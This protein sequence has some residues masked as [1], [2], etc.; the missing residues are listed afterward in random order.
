MVPPPQLPYVVQPGPRAVFADSQGWMAIVDS[1]DASH[2]AASAA[3]E[4]LI[5]TRW[6]IYTSNWTLYEA[7]SHIKE[8]AK[9]GGLSAA[10][11]LRDFAD[12]QSALTI[13]PV[14]KDVESRAVKLFWDY[15]DK[16]WSVTVCASIVLMRD[17]TLTHILS[18]NHHFVQAGFTCLY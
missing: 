3:L 10:K 9:S 4:H 6:H 2:K 12:T 1:Q 11:A 14:T 15:E 7:L 5:A 13:L 18:G 16:A 17:L 8:R